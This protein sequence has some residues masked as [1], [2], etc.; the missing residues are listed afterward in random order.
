MSNKFSQSFT[1]NAVGKPLI[2]YLN[3]SKLKTLLHNQDM[4]KNVSLAHQRISF[5]IFALRNRKVIHTIPTSINHLMS[6]VIM[7]TSCCIKSILAYKASFMVHSHFWWK[8]LECRVSYH[9]GINHGHCQS[10]PNS[11]NLNNLSRIA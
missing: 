6:D 2:T 8:S 3:N 9:Y 7:L 11:S 10:S 5:V 4:L 1:P